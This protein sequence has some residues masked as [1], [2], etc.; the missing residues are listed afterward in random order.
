M[1]TK[2]YIFLVFVCM[3]KL[4]YVTIFAKCIGSQITQKAFHKYRCVCYTFYYCYVMTYFL[5]DRLNPWSL[6][7]Y[8]ALISF[9]FMTCWY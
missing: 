2:D 5:N 3:A 6:M 8:I 9:Y 7:N 1:L 4:L